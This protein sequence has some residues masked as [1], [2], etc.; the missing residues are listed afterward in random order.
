VN[1]YHVGKA[2]GGY[3]L[4]ACGWVVLLELGS[5]HKLEQTTSGYKGGSEK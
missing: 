3:Y 5:Y 2:L 4:D 1:G